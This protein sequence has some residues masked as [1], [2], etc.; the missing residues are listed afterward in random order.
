MRESDDRLHLTD[1]FFT[2]GSAHWRW[3]RWELFIFHEVRDV[4]PT[5]ESGRVLVV[6]RGPAHPERWHRALRDAQQ[7]DPVH[8]AAEEREPRRN[9]E[10]QRANHR[11]ALNQKPSGRTRLA[12]LARRVRTVLALFAFAAKQGRK[13]PRATETDTASRLD[14]VATYAPRGA[15]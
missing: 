5:S 15:W 12:G 8:G 9:G 10:A 7:E 2:D 4:L 1:L 3:I 14:A 11:P 6:H 13:P